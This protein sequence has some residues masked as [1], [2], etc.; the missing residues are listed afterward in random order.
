MQSEIVQSPLNYTGGKYKILTQ[1]LLLFPQN[2]KTFVDIFCGGCNVGIN[3]V[4][5][6][7]IYNDCNKYLIDLFNIFKNV[8]EKIIF[9]E[10]YK[11]IKNYKL[12]D[13][14]KNGYEYYNCDS[15]KGLATYNKD[16]FLKLRRDFN[17][18][19]SI[20]KNSFD[21]NIMFYVMIIYS[22]NN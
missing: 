11:I 17:K 22:F 12:S 3:V 1:I 2:I 16:K 9:N 13:V 21:E 5:K 20:K 19:K 15:S 7:V 18:R 6:K 10:I 8:D 14:N 4:S